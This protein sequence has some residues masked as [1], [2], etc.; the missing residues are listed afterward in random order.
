VTARWVVDAV[1]PER[2]LDIT[3]KPISLFFKNEPAEDSD[4]YGPTLRTHRLLRVFMSVQDKNGNDAAF[5]LY[6]ELGSRIH[7]DGDLEFTAEAALASPGLDAAHAAAFDDE[8]WDQTI[9][10]GMDG[11]L[12]LAG[13]DVGTPIIAF[14][15]NAG[16]RVALFGPVIT[17]VPEK[18]DALDL[19][20][21]FMKV[22]RVPGFWEMKRTRTVSPDFGD[23]PEV[24]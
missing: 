16:E 23:R 9:R 15:D 12:A 18:D 6:W 19:W 22:S 10:E 24:H 4:Y 14:E 8:S 1:S 13:Q 5:R 17:R 2:D 11:G 20:D 3:W 7:H 21:G